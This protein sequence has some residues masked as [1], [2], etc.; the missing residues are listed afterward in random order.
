M[1][2]EY[3]FSILSD[4]EVGRSITAIEIVGRGTKP[5]AEIGN[6]TILPNQVE[7]LEREI[8]T[9][10]ALAREPHVKGFLMA[11]DEGRWVF[12][13]YR[14]PWVLEALEFLDQDAHLLP[15]YHRDWIS[16]LLFGY[17]PSAVQEFLSTHLTC[18]S[19]GQDTMSQR[20]DALG[21]GETRL[22]CSGRSH[23][24][25]P[26]NDRFRTVYLHDL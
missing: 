17:T 13:F 7:E 4:Y 3:K 18:W 19:G 22:P 1:L 5:L 16:G 23:N 24:H 11:Q 21:K 20:Y 6:T 8:K 15:E 10:L 26:A 2:P 14:E 9:C 12:G 25:S